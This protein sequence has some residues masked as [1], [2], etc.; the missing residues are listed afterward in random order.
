MFR[1]YVRDSWS[2]LN[3]GLERHSIENAE[4]VSIFHKISESHL[5]RA[6]PLLKDIY[7]Q[8]IRRN[9]DVPAPFNPSTNS[10]QGTFPFNQAGT[11][12][13]NQA[14]TFPFNQA[15]TFPFNQA[16]TSPLNQADTLPFSNGDDTRGRML[17]NSRACTRGRK[18]CP[19]FHPEPAVSLGIPT[20]SKSL[21]KSKSPIA[22]THS[23]TPG[24][25]SHQ[26]DIKVDIYQPYDL[27]VKGIHTIAPGAGA[28]ADIDKLEASIRN[29][30]LSFK[31]V[32][33]GSTAQITNSFVQGTVYLDMRVPQ[34]RKQEAK[35][36]SRLLQKRITTRRI[37]RL[38][39][40][41][42]QA[43]RSLTEWGEL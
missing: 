21:S 36:I 24:Q 1:P 30:P 37:E 4:A 13:F 8:L 35:K 25:H 20:P 22:S 5:T 23:G 43:I 10:V 34:S 7:A 15:G 39:M 17:M 3:R 19:P 41:N 14:G 38:I 9:N 16:G 29:L 18:N 32:Q 6:V 27:R 42:E 26:N 2:D 11:F 33:P 31:V 12:P 40:T 28:S